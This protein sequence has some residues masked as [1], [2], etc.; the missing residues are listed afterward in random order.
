MFYLMID[1]LPHSILVPSCHFYLSCFSNTS[2][3]SHPAR[4]IDLSSFCPQLLLKLGLIYFYVFFLFYLV[5]YIL[6]WRWVA[7]IKQGD[8]PINGQVP[9]GACGRESTCQCRRHRRCG[10][11]SLVGKVPWRRAWQPTP[12]FFPENPM[13][14]GTWWATLHR[15]SN[16]WTQLSTYARTLLQKFR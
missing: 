10:F 12:I 9:G 11:D 3:A 15:V 7:A 6:E 13:E 2:K 14:R 16:S 4:D 5:I 1:L 8:G